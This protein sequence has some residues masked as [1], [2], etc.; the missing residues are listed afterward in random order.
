MSGIGQGQ[1]KFVTCKGCPDRT[2]E[3]NCHTVC[4]GYLYRADRQKRINEASKDSSIYW[5]YKHE[6]FKDG[7]I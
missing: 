5:G 6:K 1:N 4:R 3:P 7:Q 2:I